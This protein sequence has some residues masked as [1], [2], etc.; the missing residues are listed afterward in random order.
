MSSDDLLIIIH[1][2]ICQKVPHYEIFDYAMSWLNEQIKQDTVTQSDEDLG[3]FVRI[4]HN[5]NYEYLAPIYQL[6]VFTLE[7]V[8][9]TFRRWLEKDAIDDPAYTRR[10]LIVQQD[11]HRLFA[12]EAGSDRRSRTDN[13]AAEIDEPGNSR[14]GDKPPTQ[15]HSDSCPKGAETDALAESHEIASTNSSPKR[16]ALCRGRDRM[17]SSEGPEPSRLPKKKPKYICK[18]CDKPGHLLH[19]CPTNWTPF[20][21][22]HPPG[23]TGACFVVVK[24]RERAAAESQESRTPNRNGRPLYRSRD[25]STR[26]SQDHYRSRSPRQHHR[27][28]YRSRSPG[29]YYRR[30]DASRKESDRLDGSDISS[31]TARARL[32]LEHHGSSKSSR[33]RDSSSQSERQRYTPSPSSCIRSPIPERTGNRRIDLGKLPRNSDEGRLA[34]DDEVSMITE[35]TSP[36][37]Y[38][39]GSTSSR[40][41]ILASEGEIS[42]A[43]SSPTK[44][45]PDDLSK[46]RQETEG[47]LSALAADIMSK[48]QG[49][50]QFV[51][52]NTHDT[53]IET[54]YDSCC[55]AGSDNNN[56]LSAT[57]GSGR[58]AAHTASGL[59]YRP[60]HSPAFS[61]EI[62]SLFNARENPII[63]KRAK[64]KTASQ[65]MNDSE[66]LGTHCNKKAGENTVVPFRF[67]CRTGTLYVVFSSLLEL[68]E[69]LE[70][71][72][73]DLLA[74][75]LDL[76]GEEDLVEDGVD[77]VEVED[78]V[79]LADVAE[80]G[81]EHL[82]E[83][84]DRLEVRELVVVGVDAR[85][86]E[87]ARVPPVHDLVVPELDEVGLVLL[88][89]RRYEAVH[90]EKGERGGGC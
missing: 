18:R 28:Y 11:V 56:I 48:G 16:E 47:F 70:A 50:A 53:T 64:R 58:P 33:L 81:V 10:Y 8:D 3:R 46:I 15:E 30:T 24:R 55:E 34:Y 19:L 57:T 72:E 2:K 51:V 42:R 83:E 52:V 59:E 82:D 4:L 87:E 67:L 7:Q 65:M 63:N 6:P 9:E 49:P 35:T 89:P 62:V 36:P 80:E 25:N 84:V 45:A 39:N 41:S 13:K 37:S 78:E 12:S 68:I 73:D 71:R 77:L 14:P 90:L 74:R 43:V 32:P 75:L 60:V 86:E 29:R 38:S 17:R 27:E 1:E 66:S 23:I 61:S 88:V 69:M 26:R 20:T 85:A 54:G 76:A 5:R 40:C 22:R 79:E 31:Y 44:L 21:I